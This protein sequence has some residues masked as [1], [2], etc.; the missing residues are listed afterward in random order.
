MVNLLVRNLL[1]GCCLTVLLSACSTVR[2][3]APLPVTPLPADRLKFEGAW[4]SND[5]IIFVRFGSNGVVRLAGIDWKNDD[6]V[7]EKG[8]FTIT[9]CKND[10]NLLS[11]RFQEN[12]VWTEGYFFVRYRFD[13][14]GNLILWRP[15]PEVFRDLVAG[16]TLKGTVKKGDYSLD[17]L[18]TDGGDSILAYLNSGER[19]KLFDYQE[20]LVMRRVTREKIA[21]KKAVNDGA[22]TP[23]DKSATK[24]PGQDAAGK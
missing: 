8:E 21:E 16:G 2:I 24:N 4:Q 14:Q 17:V 5:E 12:G 19:M 15:I 20:P 3:S 9:E 6:F 13:D 23:A 18:L 1:V 22:K 11:V 7:V 10:S